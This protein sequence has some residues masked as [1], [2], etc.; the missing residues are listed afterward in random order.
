MI[1]TDLT[2]KVALITGPARDI[3]K[4]IAERYARLGADV[5][6]N[7]SN[8]KTSADATV[9][10]IQELGGKA[11]SVRWEGW[12]PGTSWST[13][14]ARGTL[15]GWSPLAPRTGGAP[16]SLVQAR[17][18]AAGAARRAARGDRPPSFHL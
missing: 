2:G 9:A 10:R 4:A 5:V 6:I 7:Y 12:W 8:D 18:S 11:I 1:M 13:W 3:G 14:R 15:A 17:T 16:V